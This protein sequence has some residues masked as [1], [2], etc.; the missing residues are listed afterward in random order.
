MKYNLID[1]IFLAWA[2]RHALQVYTD[3][4]GEEVRIVRM[5]GRGK[6]FADVFIDVTPEGCCVVGVGIARRPSRNSQS[7]KH[8]ADLES[9]DST[10]DLAYSKAQ[11]WLNSST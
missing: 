3:C 1:P 9:L 11:A 2:K 7:E 5:Y 4:K 8:V 10:L 6:E